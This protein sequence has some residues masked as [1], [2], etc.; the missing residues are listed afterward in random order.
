M[1]LLQLLLFI[2]LMPI[3]W[4]VQ[5]Q[6]NSEQEQYLRFTI[7]SLGGLNEVEG[8]FTDWSIELIES[9]SPVQLVRLSIPVDKIKTGID[10]RDKALMEEEYFDANSYPFIIVEARIHKNSKGRSDIRSVEISIK[11]ISRQIGLANASNLEV[12]NN[13][14]W[15]K[16][17]V[18]LDR[19]DWK[20]AS[21]GS[22]SISRQLWL[23][24]NLLLPVR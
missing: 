6:T 4:A 10:R 8:Y 11:G 7:G 15:A 12:V 9:N 23:D 19:Y 13:K 14:L 24:F 2:L 20:I 3:Y 16:G 5:A 1:R 18:T 17:R 22:F 21:A